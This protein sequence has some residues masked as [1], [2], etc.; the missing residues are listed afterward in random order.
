MHESMKQTKIYMLVDAIP[1]SL[2]HSNV[3]LRW[4]QWKSKELGH[5]PWLAT[6]G[7]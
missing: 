2:I 5:V 3:N 1:S 4:K 6:L 7:G